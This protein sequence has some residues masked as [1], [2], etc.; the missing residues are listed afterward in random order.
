MSVMPGTYPS[1]TELNLDV[2][3]GDVVPARVKDEA[4]VR[5][6]DARP[7]VGADDVVAQDER[8][9]STVLAAREHDAR[10]L[11]GRR[12]ACVAHDR[13]PANLDV[14]GDDGRPLV[15]LELEQDP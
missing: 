11:G 14:R 7:A 10:S 1:P 6:H 9:R 3:P 5:Q 8:S 12:L 15:G 13:V 2:V 4:K